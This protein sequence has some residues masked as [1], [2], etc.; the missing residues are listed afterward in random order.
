MQGAFC[1][2]VRVTSPVRHGTMP[3][4]SLRERH[5]VMRLVSGADSHSPPYLSYPLKHPLLME[6]AHPRRIHQRTC[7]VVIL[8]TVAPAMGALPSPLSVS[9]TDTAQR[10]FRR[11]GGSQPIGAE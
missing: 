1:Q 5:S 2:A 10:R 9:V 8:T 4:K 7:A 6:G 3:G 11:W